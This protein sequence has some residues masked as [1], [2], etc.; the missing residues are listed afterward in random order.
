MP[1]VSVI[2]PTFNSES[3]LRDTINSVLGQSFKDFELIIVDDCST[4]KTVDIIKSFSHDKRVIYIK[5][6]DNLGP[7]AC[8]NLGMAISKGELLAFLDSDDIFLKD[9]LKRQIAIFEK[10]KSCNF[11]YTNETYFKGD[12]CKSIQSGRTH[13]K[14]DVFFY[15]KR[16]NFVTVSTVMIRK[17]IS[18]KYMFDSSPEVKGHEDWKFYLKLAFDGFKFYYIDEP[19]SKIRLRHGSVTTSEN[20]NKSRKEVGLVAKECW[21]SFKKTINLHTISGIKAFLRYITLKGKALIRGFPHKKCFN[22]PTPHER[23]INKEII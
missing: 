1:K 5:S 12:I 11:C 8:R 9:K 21:K 16:S 19:L 14:G 15:L 13:F 18:E 20:M 2:V 7:A 22:L 4:D 23:F 10:N 17:F 6:K 3:T